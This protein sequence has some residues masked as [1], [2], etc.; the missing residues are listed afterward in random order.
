MKAIF[1]SWPFLAFST[2]G[3]F[4]SLAYFVPYVMLPDMVIEHG[5]SESGA[6][7]IITVSG[8]SSK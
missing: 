6:A 4:V 2:S 3:F 7:L 1:K 5:I 8:I